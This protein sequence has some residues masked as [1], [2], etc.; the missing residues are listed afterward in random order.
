MN[1]QLAWQNMK[2]TC[3]AFAT[4]PDTKNKSDFCQHRKTWIVPVGSK[5]DD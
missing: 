3:K 4:L 2:L 1:K 5:L